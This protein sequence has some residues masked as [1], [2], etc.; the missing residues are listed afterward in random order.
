M[1]NL[2]FIVKELLGAGRA[3]SGAHAHPVLRRA[4][5][6]AEGHHAASPRSLFVIVDQ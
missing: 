3:V 1:N 6:L 2:R 4:I 5:R